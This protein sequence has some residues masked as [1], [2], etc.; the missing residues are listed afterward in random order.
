MDTKFFN[1][2]LKNILTFFFLIFK[3]IIYASKQYITNVNYDVI[4]FYFISK[5]Y[6]K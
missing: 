3:Q 1:F 5:D 2:A 6:L 4:I